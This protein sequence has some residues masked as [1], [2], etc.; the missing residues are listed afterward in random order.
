M[1]KQKEKKTTKRSSQKKSKGFPNKGPNKAAFIWII[2]IISTLLL[3]RMSIPF[4][5]A[6]VMK[7][8]EFYQILKRNPETRQIASAALKGERIIA[9]FANGNRLEGGN[10]RSF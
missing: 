1:E 10:F 7:D 4:E 3:L 6:S 8:G 5:G 9:T 2:L